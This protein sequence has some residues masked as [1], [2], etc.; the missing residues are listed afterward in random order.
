MLKKCPCH[1]GKM[2]ADCCQPLHSGALPENALALM[3]SRYAAY[4]LKL[5]DYIVLTTHPKSALYE[6]NKDLWKAAIQRF[7]AN[8]QFEGL[9]IHACQENGAHAEVTFTA[10]LMQ[11]GKD[12]S[13]TERSTFEQINGRW[14]YLAGQLC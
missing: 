9:E 1:S 3:R 2:Y 6:R 8:T 14:L 13:F 11:G 12:A 5:S 4:A 7:A 10:H